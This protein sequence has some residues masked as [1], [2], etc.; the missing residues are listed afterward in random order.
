MRGG[1]TPTSEESLGNI[2]RVVNWA[3]RDDIQVIK[4][5]VVGVRQRS[6]QETN[7]QSERVIQQAQGW[8]VTSDGDVFL[9]AENPQVI[10]QNSGIQH[11]DCHPS[12]KN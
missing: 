9:T 12:I 11:P 4:N 7:Q 3:S 10:L 6:A 8:V 2:D 1:L 5:G